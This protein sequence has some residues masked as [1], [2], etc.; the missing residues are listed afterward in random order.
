[1]NGGRHTE[2]PTDK[3]RRLWNEIQLDPRTSLGETNYIPQNLEKDFRVK[4]S[5]TVEG[6][7]ANTTSNRSD[8][9]LILTHIS[10]ACTR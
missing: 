3:P 1:M 9:G 10:F 8:T 2:E 5:M 4:C 7:V 6:N